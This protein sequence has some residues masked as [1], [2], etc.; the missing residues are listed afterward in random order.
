VLQGVAVHC[1]NAV[2]LSKS[3]RRALLCY[4][5]LLCVAACCSVLQCSVVC[6][7]RVVQFVSVCRSVSYYVVASVSRIDKI[8][9]LL[10]K[11]ALQK[12]RY[13]A[14][15]TPT[16]CSHPILCCAIFEVHTYVLLMYT[17]SSFDP[18]M[19]LFS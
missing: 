16:D 9:G 12:R 13:S 3:L 17:P 4:I 8:I 11:R 5:V 7:C 2:L 1:I 18:Y 6:C 14:K 19:G 15:E 10:C